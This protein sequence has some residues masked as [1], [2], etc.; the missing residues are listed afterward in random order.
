MRKDCKRSRT[1][2][3]LNRR[4]E[5]DIPAPPKLLHIQ[6]IFQLEMQDQIYPRCKVDLR[7]GLF[8]LLGYRD[9]FL[10]LDLLTAK[11]LSAADNSC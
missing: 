6:E 3:R 10:W 8:G 9:I 5:L 2:G 7:Q 4:E 11:L 1:R